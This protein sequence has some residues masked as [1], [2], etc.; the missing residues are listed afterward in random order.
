MK[1]YSVIHYIDNNGSYYE[2][3]VRYSSMNKN[4]AEKYFFDLCFDLFP[5]KLFDDRLENY[6]EVYLDTSTEDWKK[7]QEKIQKIKNYIRLCKEDKK[8]YLQK[9]F[10]II[11]DK[12]DPEEEIYLDSEKCIYYNG[13]KNHYGECYKLIEHDVND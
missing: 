1:C 11:E 9:L 4:K 6:D 2:F 13:L 10:D 3:E 8:L 7:E 12:D 5:Y